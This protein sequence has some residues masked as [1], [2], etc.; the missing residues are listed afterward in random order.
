MAYATTEKE[1][2]AIVWALQE[3]HPYLYG[4]KFSDHQR[5]KN[6]NQRLLR[7]SLP[8]Q[9]YDFDIKHKTGKLNGNGDGLS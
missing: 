8:L 3:L 6:N 9:E 5:I 4:Q 7:W 2:L 1:C